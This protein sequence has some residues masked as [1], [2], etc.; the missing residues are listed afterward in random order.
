MSRIDKN[1]TISNTKYDAGIGKKIYSDNDN[2]ILKVSDI[3]FDNSGRKD[4][5]IAYKN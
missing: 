2:S 5:I 3:D 4:L 1:N